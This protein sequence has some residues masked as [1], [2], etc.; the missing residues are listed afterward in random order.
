MATANVPSHREPAKTQRSEADARLSRPVTQPLLDSVEPHFSLS[1]TGKSTS[2]SRETPASE[3]KS[4]VGVVEDWTWTVKLF[5]DGHDWNAVMT[6][7]RMTDI[8][9][10]GSL[11]NAIQSGARIDRNWLIAPDGGTDRTVGQQRVHRELQR[12]SAAGVS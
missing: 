8:E 3:A 6:I 12:R 11:V 9:V 10:A 7:R 2:P 1:S 4:G 5:T